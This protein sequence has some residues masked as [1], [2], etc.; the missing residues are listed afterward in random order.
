MS[1]IK[2]TPTA[3]ILT[4]L[5][6]FSP[7]LLHNMTTLKD[8]Q[9][10]TCNSPQHML[11]LFINKSSN[12]TL[13]LLACD[14]LIEVAK[15][16]AGIS[17]KTTEMIYLARQHADKN[18]T[19]PSIEN[20]TEDDEIYNTW[21]ELLYGQ[22]M[23]EFLLRQ[24]MKIGLLDLILGFF[25]LTT[26]EPL[27]DTTPIAK[28][29]ANLIR[30]A[31][32]FPPGIVTL[33]LGRRIPCTD[34]LYGTKRPYHKKDKP[35]SDQYV[36]KC[37]KCKGS[38]TI[39]MPHPWVD[40]TVYSLVQKAYSCDSEDV[41]GTLDNVLLNVIADALEENKCTNTALINH[42]RL[43]NTHYKSCWALNLLMSTY[44]GKT[45]I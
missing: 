44:H 14:V 45:Q 23:E 26:E 42:L 25:P 28:T 16:H 11:E 21:E 22:A 34:C 33:P 2:K 17:E 37:E 24:D 40:E 41:A 27:T 35:E 12:R 43:P 15:V 1:Y 6:I 36:V 20:I 19:D 10:Y 9:W 39:L 5:N 3:Q 18:L 8:H 30:D 13:R 38:C 7:L 31:I 4:D 29:V 32:S